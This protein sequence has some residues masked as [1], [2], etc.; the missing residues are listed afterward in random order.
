MQAVFNYKIDYKSNRAAEQI[1]TQHKASTG[2]MFTLLG[3]S[4]SQPEKY[5]L[6]GNTTGH[7]AIVHN[8]VIRTKKDL[9]KDLF[10]PTVHGI[11][12]SGYG[13]FKAKINKVTTPEYQA[14]KD[15]LKRI[16]G[17][18]NIS[19][20]LYVDYT[21]DPEWLNFQTFAAWH[22]KNFKDGYV[23]ESDLSGD[24]RYGPDSCVMVHSWIN[25][26]VQTLPAGNPVHTRN[27]TKGN[28]GQYVVK[29]GNVLAHNRTRLYI[30]SF[31]TLEEAT[32]RRN[33]AE[34]QVLANIMVEMRELGYS[35]SIIKSVVRRR[36][37][38]INRL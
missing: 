28:A 25:G 31:A 3:Q 26:Y 30:G 20:H 19:S 34:D 1:G 9:F 17:N 7:F 23:I 22:H 16:S 4:I 35:E 11:G 36:L 27:I 12:Y 2:E 32:L 14:W 8:T 38:N 13:D 15:M 37:S 18:C 10:S 21:I 33:M 5:V 24:K 29:V 6:K